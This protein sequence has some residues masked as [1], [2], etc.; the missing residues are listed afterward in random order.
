MASFQ[1]VEKGAGTTLLDFYLV[2]SAYTDPIAVSAAVHFSGIFQD[3][4][5]NRTV[6][7]DVFMPATATEKHHVP[8]IGDSDMS[9]TY[10]Q[11]P[12]GAVFVPGSYYKRVRTNG[13]NSDAGSYWLCVSNSDPTNG[14]G[15]QMVTATFVQAKAS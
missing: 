8:T 14:Q 10:Y 9:I 11:T 12:G 15:L 7:A 13:F 5:N 3:L 6:D 4:S 2:T 1:Q